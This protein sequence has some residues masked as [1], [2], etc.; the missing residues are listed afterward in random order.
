MLLSHSL[1]TRSID[2]ACSVQIH[3]EYTINM[4]FM[5]YSLTYISYSNMRMHEALC[6]SIIIVHVSVCDSVFCKLV[7]M[8]MCTCAN[9]AVCVCV[10]V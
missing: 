6:I 7:C 1:F 9:I 10:C 3:V 8:I 5:Y 2:T 4:Y